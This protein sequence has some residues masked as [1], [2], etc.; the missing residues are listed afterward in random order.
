[1]KALLQLAGIPHSTYYYW[2]NTFGMPD[3]DSELKTLFKRFMR[4][5]R[6]VMVIAVFETS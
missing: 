3:K 4:S 1:M 6:G 2:V 5:I